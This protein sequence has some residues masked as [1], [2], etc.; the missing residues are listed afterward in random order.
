VGDRA[1]HFAICAFADNNVH[2]EH[3]ASAVRWVKKVHSDHIC[4]SS[5]DLR[6]R[7]Q[8]K[9]TN[10][11]PC[12][13][14]LRPARLWPGYAIVHHSPSTQIYTSK[15]FIRDVRIMQHASFHCARHYTPKLAAKR[16]TPS[17]FS[18][19]QNRVPFISARCVAT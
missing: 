8:E 2:D 13:V 11:R 18:A 16:K 6:C 3:T 17:S 15:Y 1:F 10:K 7:C 9:E 4:V 19:I 12:S 5:N 14:V